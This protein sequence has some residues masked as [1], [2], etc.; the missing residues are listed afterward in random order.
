[1]GTLTSP[2]NYLDQM[3]ELFTGYSISLQEVVNLMADY[4]MYGDT[5]Q[6]IQTT[7]L[8]N[9]ETLQQNMGALENLKIGLQQDSSTL[10]S[11]IDQMNATI[12]LENAKLNY[13][14][15]QYSQLLGTNSASKGALFDT[16][17]LYNQQYIGN[18][19][20]LFVILCYAKMIY[21]KYY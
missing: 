6:N 7:Y 14:N 10:Q 17:L 8:T 18:I 2:Q 21:S 20:L 16:Q 15:E 3:Q 11:Q 12:D 4:Q 5:D 13:L 9:L 1:M 19:L